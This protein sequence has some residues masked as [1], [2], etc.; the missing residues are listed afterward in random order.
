MSGARS[1]SV[2]IDRLTE[3]CPRCVVPLSVAGQVVGRVLD[4]AAHHVLARRR[5]RGVHER[6]D[7]A[8]DVRTSRRE[9]RTSRRR[10]RA[11]CSRATARTRSRRAATAPRPGMQC[12][13]G[14]PVQR[15][16]HLAGGAPDTCT[17][18]LLTKAGSSHVS[19][20]NLTKVH[21]SRALEN[22]PGSDLLAGLKHDALRTPCSG[23]RSG[24]PAPRFGSRHRGR[25]PRPR[26]RSR[27]RRCR[28]E[29]APRRGT[30]RRSRPCSDG[31]A[32]RR[33]LASGTPRNVPM[34]P[35]PPSSP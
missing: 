8:V 19:S 30:L 34:M 4:E 17:E 32:R 5:H 23:Q 25:A 1:W 14:Q 9:R 28:L 15:Q 22:G 10:K 31:A 29:A 3:R 13:L 16:V 33:C 18:D 7:D 26:S 12:K 2:S 11:P 35:E 6:R 20:S 24:R 27:C 21:R